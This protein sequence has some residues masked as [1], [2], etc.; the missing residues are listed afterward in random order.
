MHEPASNDPFWK[1]SKVI[2]IPRKSKGDGGTS[3]PCGTR[4][5]RVKMTLPVVA[6]ANDTA[7]RHHWRLHFMESGVKEPKA[8]GAYATFDD[9]CGIVEGTPLNPTRILWCG[10]QSGTVIGTDYETALK[11]AD[12]CDTCRAALKL[13]LDV[14]KINGEKA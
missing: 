2:R 8:P 4:K 11:E 14:R 13:W 3:E 1:P 12:W 7:S 10:L 9:N 5:R 6:R